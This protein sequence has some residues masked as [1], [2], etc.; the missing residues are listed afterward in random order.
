MMEIKTGDDI[1]D[2]HRTPAVSHLR[3]SEDGKTVIA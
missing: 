1:D 2:G 3:G